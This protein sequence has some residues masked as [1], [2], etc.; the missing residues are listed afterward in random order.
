MGWGQ[1]AAVAVA[2]PVAALLI[3]GCGRSLPAGWLYV[4]RVGPSTAIVVWTGRDAEALA[5][6]GPDGRRTEVV[7]EPNRHDLRIARLGGLLP[8]TRYVCRVERVA[9]GQVL[10]RLSFRTAGDPE[11]P[12]T[13]AV[14]GDTGDGSPQAATLARRIRAGRPDFLVHLGDMAYPSGTPAEYDARFFRPY[15]RT[16]ARVPLFPTPGNHDLRPRSVYRRLFAPIADGEDAGGPHYA[17]VWGHAYFASISSPSFT[18]GGAVGVR[19]LAENLADARLRAFR[20]VF[21]HEPLYTAGAKVTVPGLRAV[22]EP[23]LEASHTDLLLTGHQHFYERA[24]PAC[25][26]VSGASVMEISSGGGG[27]NLDP[28]ATHPNFA[29]DVSATHY[30]RV[31]VTPD[32]LELRAIGLDG[33]VLDHVRRRRGEAAPCRSG[34]WPPPHD[35]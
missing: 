25:E 35:R 18:K 20:I 22:L 9:S 27:A 11:R 14:V 23:L 15:R 19:W 5:C 30:V 32:L 29:R 3:G 4:S 1:R 34:G 33:R 8:G 13:F 21:L 17:F 28:Q 26:H 12:F 24:E 31:R 10:H 2:G 6:R 7:G 16:L